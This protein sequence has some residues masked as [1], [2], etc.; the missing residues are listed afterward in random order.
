M[1][2]LPTV[3]ECNTWILEQC[4][5]LLSDIESGNFDIKETAQTTYDSTKILI[6]ALDITRKE[7]TKLLN[8][9]ERY[10]RFKQNNNMMKL[11]V[12]RKHIYKDNG[13]NIFNLF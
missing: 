8:K 7:K 4:Q 5:I 3:D 1:N 13:F 9:L 10:S 12:S 2:T 6:N 11:L